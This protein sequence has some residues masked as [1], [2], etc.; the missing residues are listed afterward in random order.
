VGMARAGA[1]SRGGGK[2]PRRREHA[3]DPCAQKMPRGSWSAGLYVRRTAS[4]KR[5]IIHRVD[6]AELP[7]R[8]PLSL[9]RREA[10]LLVRIERVSDLEERRFD[11]ETGI[12]LAAA[13]QFTVYYTR[14]ELGSRPGALRRNGPLSRDPRA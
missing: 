5:A 11:H 3:R 12:G 7:P 8:A 2:D 4:E 1:L 13:S 14:S 6:A 10:L 9:H